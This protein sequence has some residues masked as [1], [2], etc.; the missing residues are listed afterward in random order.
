MEL[1]K[2][3]ILSILV[4]FILSGC[5][6]D[7]NSKNTGETSSGSIEILS[8]AEGVTTPF[9]FITLEID[10]S[11]HINV[12]AVNDTISKDYNRTIVIGG[13]ENYG[14]QYLY[15]VPLTKG[16]N[17]INVT[18]TTDNNQVVS[19]LLNIIS[20]EKGEALRFSLSQKEGIG[21]LSTKIEIQHALTS[22]TEYMLDKDSDGK[23]DIKAAYENTLNV[24]Y[25]ELGHYTAMVTLRTAN[26]LLY[27]SLLQ[28]SNSVHVKEKYT[29]TEVSA[30]SGIKVVDMQAGNESSLYILADDNKVYHLNQETEEIVETI[31]LEGVSNP[32]GLSVYGNKV[33]FIA[34]TGNTR[35]VV[36]KKAEDGSYKEDKE[37]FRDF[38]FVEGTGEFEFKK[39]VD[40][41]ASHHSVFILDSEN[42]KLIQVFFLLSGKTS[43]KTIDIS[44]DKLGSLNNPLNIDGMI[45]DSENYAIRSGDEYDLYL[46]PNVT[47]MGK[48][49]FSSGRDILADK[50]NKR[51]I[52]PFENKIR[53]E[54]ILEKSPLIAVDFED[55][56]RGLTYTYVA[57]VEGGLY[58]LVDDP[59]ANGGQPQD[60]VD[61]FIE[62]LK[63][64]SYYDMK[65]YCDG[66]NALTSENLEKLRLILPLIT[67]YESGK[68]VLGG[69]VWAYYTLEGKEQRLVFTLVRVNGR[70]LIRGF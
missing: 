27:T 2:I 13:V 25:N 49:T 16:V 70:L 29:E 18:A 63:K 19:K 47:D 65:K 59:D 56:D 23:I 54:I 5:G 20:E 48:V 51:L 58:K 37:Y 31:T 43:L 34:D 39:I 35:V 44:A 38:K 28:A 4:I 8:P 11:G 32:Q 1:G 10:A 52:Y 40:V 7:E 62:A 33:I 30:L 50:G 6:S 17:E 57:Y 55:Y 46:N 61:G 9:S 14:L 53:K 45:S 41:E 69:A 60:I 3:T 21:E 67:H 66:S 64:D 26:N 15:N 68:D 36:Y 24:T 22:P 12:T 42:N